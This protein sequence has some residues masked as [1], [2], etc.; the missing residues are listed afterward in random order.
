MKYVC[1][2]YI[3]PGKFENMPE[4][5]RNAMLDE[6][7]AYDDLLREGGHFIGGEILQS[8]DS[9]RTLIWKNGKVSV[10]DGPYCE[11]KE[12][13]GGL[14]MLE[15]RDLNQAIELMSK[16]PGVR[17]GTFEIREVRDRTEI[18]RVSEKRRAEVVR[19]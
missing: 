2:G 3:E 12:H 4:S 13:I 9:A 10:T 17:L 1:F 19:V 15:A 5:E 14:L 16:H 6:C 11:S 18:L 8:A 7:F